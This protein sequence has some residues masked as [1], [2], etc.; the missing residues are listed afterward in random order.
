[1]ADEK[2]IKKLLALMRVPTAKVRVN[3]YKNEMVVFHTAEM[4]R[5]K[6]WTRVSQ[7]AWV[8]YDETAS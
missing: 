7:L 2:Q 8:A 3:R 4:K 1:M 6:T 5:N